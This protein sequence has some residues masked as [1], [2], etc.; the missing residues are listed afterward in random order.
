[1]LGV[2]TKIGVKGLLRQVGPQETPR[3][4]FGIPRGLTLEMAAKPEEDHGQQRN[5]KGNLK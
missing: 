4:P 2:V 3:F 1:M 5:H